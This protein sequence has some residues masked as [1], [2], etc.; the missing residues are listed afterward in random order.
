MKRLHRFTAW[1]VLFAILGGFAT[2]AAG[3]VPRAVDR[4]IRLSARR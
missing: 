1:M 3:Q 4:E 2:W